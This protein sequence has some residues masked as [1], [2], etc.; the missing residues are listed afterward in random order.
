M[1]AE[2]PLYKVA[3]LQKRLIYAFSLQILFGLAARVVETHDEIVF[4]VC[5][6]IA[7]GCLLFGVVYGYQLA[8]NLGR[9]GVIFVIGLFIPCLNL[10]VLLA[11]T[12]AATRVLKNGGVEVGLFGPPESEL[13][14]LREAP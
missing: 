13:R 1:S 11:L 10:L 2:N 4:L 14:R 7:L 9:S 12:S 8:R 6:L 3:L 5:A